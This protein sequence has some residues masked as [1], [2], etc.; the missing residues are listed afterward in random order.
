MLGV[1]QCCTRPFSFFS[2]YIV[3]TFIQI[4]RN[5]RITSLTY[6]QYIYLY[7]IYD[8]LCTH[9][10]YVLCLCTLYSIRMYIICFRSVLTVRNDKLKNTVITYTAEYCH[11]LDILKKSNKINFLILLSCQLVSY[12]YY[13]T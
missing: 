13:S 12:S 8:K 7:N 10:Y 6:I 1:V 9:T 5:T 11:N 2:L 3:G 4:I